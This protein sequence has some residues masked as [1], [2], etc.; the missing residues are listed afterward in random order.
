MFGM[1]AAV[2]QMSDD[3]W[4]GSYRPR[5]PS[6]RLAAICP[7]PPAIINGAVPLQD[8]RYRRRCGAQEGCDAVVSG[9][10][11]RSGMY[12]VDDGIHPRLLNLVQDV[13]WYD[14]L[15]SE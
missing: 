12:P 13:G 15:Q 7:S 1:Q 14:P 8:G 4:W 6:K 9:L 10:A 5:S 3:C 2:C 11:A